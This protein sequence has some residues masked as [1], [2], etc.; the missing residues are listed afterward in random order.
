MVAFSSVEKMDKKPMM[1]S[2]THSSEKYPRKQHRD[3]MT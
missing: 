1:G 3:E 2:S